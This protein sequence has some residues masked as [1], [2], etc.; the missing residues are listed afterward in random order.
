MLSPPRVTVVG[1]ANI[2]LVA[3]CQRL[4]RPGETVTD[5]TFDRFAGGKGANQA[6]AAARPGRPHEICRQD[7]NRRPRAAVARARG[8]RHKRCRA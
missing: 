1:S 2:D 8:H 4:P 5:A 3:R 7:R 6:V